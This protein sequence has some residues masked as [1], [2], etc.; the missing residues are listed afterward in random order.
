MCLLLFA[1]L[2]SIVIHPQPY[3]IDQNEFPDKVIVILHYFIASAANRA[4]APMIYLVVKI[5]DLKINPQPDKYL[6]SA[7]ITLNHLLPTNPKHLQW[8]EY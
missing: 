7:S 1:F 4:M 3:K 2:L 6:N 8:K 5:V